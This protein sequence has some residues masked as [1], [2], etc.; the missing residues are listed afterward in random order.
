MTK[1][2]TTVCPL[3]QNKNLCAVNSDDPC[4]CINTNIDPKLLKDIPTS[5][6]NKVCICQQ[7]AQSFNADKAV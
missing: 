7:C 1:I 4:W 5:M 6:K 2:D 3:C